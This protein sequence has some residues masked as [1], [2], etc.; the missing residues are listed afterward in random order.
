MTI[1]RRIGSKS[2]ILSLSLFVVAAGGVSAASLSG[3][4]VRAAQEPADVSFVLNRVSENSTMYSLV[5]SDTDERVISGTFSLERLQILR[6]IMIEAEKFAMTSEAVGAKEPITTR[7]L[8]K[9][10]PAFVCDVQKIGM[11]SA[12]FLTLMTDNGR[13]TLNAGRLIRSTRREEGIFFDILSRLETILPKL[14]AKSVK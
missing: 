12:F 4:P 8:D 7:F 14:P 5:I 2:A 1:L 9:Q 3:A 6:A 11:E 13:S 10:E